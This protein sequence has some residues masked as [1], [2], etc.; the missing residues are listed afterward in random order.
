MIGFLL[1]SFI[2]GILTAL[3]PCVLPLLP[4]IIGGSVAGQTSIRKALVIVVSLGASVFL[5]TL[6]LKASTAFI[7][8]PELFWQLLSGGLLLLFGV[9]T[10]FPSL[11]DRIPGV[12]ALYRSS[13]RM[14]GTGYQKQSIVGDILVGAALGPVFSSCSPTYFV[15]LA[16]VLPA[17]FATGILYLIA[18]VIGL[19]ISLF[20]IAFLGQ[21][22]VLALGLATD[23]NG[24]F[25]K[26]I[27][28]LFIL[29][30][31]AV[32]FGFDKKIE[33]ALPSSAFGEI[34]IEQQL[35]SQSQG[36]Q[37]PPSQESATSSSAVT[38]ASSQ[39]ATTTASSANSS[40]S[41]LLTAAEKAARYTKAPELSGIAGYINTDGQPITIEQFKGKDVVLVDFW[42]Y[43]CINCQRTLPYLEA[44]YQKYKDQGLVI[45]GVH[46]PEFAF[47]QLQSNVQ[48]AAEQFGLTYPIV[49]D[50][51]YKTWNAFANEY[52]PREYLIDIDGYIVHDHAGEGDY[53]GTEK[54][55]QD[56]LAERA[57][58][59]GTAPVSTSTVNMPTPDLSAVQSPETY[60]GSNRN[61]YLGNGTPDVQGVQTFTLPDSPEP[62]TLY[63][64]GSWNIMPEYAEGGSGDSIEFE[65]SAH[66][67]YMV[68]TNMSAD[69][70][71]KVLRDGKP[72]G[73][74]AGTDVESST[75]EATINADRLYKLIH[76]PTPGVHTITIEVESGTLDAY[77]F[78]FG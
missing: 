61:E 43:S 22:A 63:L 56:A 33:A 39:T 28:I 64:G 75:S 25:K 31:I 41:D 46:T 5:F 47:E 76:D 40:L 1:I 8:V 54:A 36:S 51:Q 12:Q 26:G 68:A 3:A 24:W 6:I 37:Q 29:V 21:K 55:I 62:N 32:I 35:L 4:V 30:G 73:S 2:A 69:V 10:L 70:K 66:D 50:N 44:W 60:F 27:G 19:S 38:Q 57:A 17:H 48:A 34:G 78:T 74:F 11:W 15:I 9:V 14:V 23:S 72:V 52:W 16:A 59:L 20:I 7:T 65:Y 42:D 13:N 18:Y 49:L 77:T 45:I 67:V 58:R 71:I 53:D